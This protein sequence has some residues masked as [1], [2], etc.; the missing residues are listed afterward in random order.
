I[1]AEIWSSESTPANE[2]NA[3]IVIEAD[4]SILI[5]CPHAE[6]GQGIT[7]ALAMIVAEEL[8]C[9]WAKVKVEYASAT[10]NLR[11]KGVYGQMWTI[12]SFGVRTSYKMLQQ[13]GASARARLIAAAA[14][15]WNVPEPECIARD[16]RIQH[17][18]SGRHFAYGD[19][20][21]DAAGIKVHSEP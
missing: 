3:F 10:R 2:L 11:D 1:S 19:L 4:N 18:R 20:V 15:R 14:R 9:D 21:R 17:S 8:E 5:R 7:T 13:A 16:S 6:M 12:G